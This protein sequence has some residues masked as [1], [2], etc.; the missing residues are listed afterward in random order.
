MYETSFPI[1]SAFRFAQLPLVAISSGTCKAA[2]KNT[3]SREVRQGTKTHKKHSAF[4]L[5]ILPSHAE[6]E[7][8]RAQINLSCLT[9]APF[10][11]ETTVKS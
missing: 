10:I 6:F 9:A 7:I 8:V 5:K 11:Y 2:L 1:P 3:K 4:P